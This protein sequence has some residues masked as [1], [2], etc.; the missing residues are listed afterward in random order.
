MNDR[1][2]IAV[3]GAGAVGGTVGA[4]LATAGHDTWFLVRESTRAHLQTHGLRLDSCDGDLQLPQVQAASDASIIGPV[5][6]VLVC[7]KATQVEAIAPTLRPL[8][9]QHTVVIPTQNGVEAGV[10]LAAALG[11]AHVSDG[12]CRVIAAL[13]GPGHIRHMAVTPVLEFGARSGGALAPAVRVTAERFASAFRLAGL[14]A[15]LPDDM[16][17]ALWEKFLF[18]EPLGLVGAA[19]RHPFGVVRTILE[20]RALIDGALDEV[21]AVGRACGVRWPSDTKARIW[22]RYDA[23]PPDGYTSMAR[24]LMAG[25]PSEYDAQTGAVIRLGRSHGVAIPVHEVL[26]AVMLPGVTR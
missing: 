11:E 4:R 24:D 8:L 25:R 9:Q 13:E 26:H 18:I 20:T 12:V 10:Q 23:L 3:I 16:G 21:I 17:V 14:Q 6:V 7:V 15:L 5:D 2:R 19:A 22:Q 1:V